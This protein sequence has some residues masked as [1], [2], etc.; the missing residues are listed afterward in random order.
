[1]PRGGKVAVALRSEPD[2]IAVEVAALGAEARLPEEVGAA[3]A[4]VNPPA[5]LTPR[6]VQAYY[7]GRLA[8]GFGQR[9]EPQLAAAGDLRF[10]A[11]L[12]A[13]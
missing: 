12:P 3:L 6:S 4:A 5:D 2:G 1:M 13:A 10:R 11:R 9:L 7:L 8:A